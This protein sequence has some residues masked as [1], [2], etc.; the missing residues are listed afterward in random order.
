[1]RTSF[2]AAYI[3][4]SGIQRR[5]RRELIQR[6]LQLQ[7]RGL[8]APM[9]SAE[10]RHQE[11]Q[12]IPYVELLAAIF[13]KGADWRIATCLEAEHDPRVRNE[14]AWW[15]SKAAIEGDADEL[16]RFQQAVKTIKAIEETAPAKRPKALALLFVLRRWFE[17]QGLPTEAQV[18][19]FLIRAGIPL[20][21]EGRK[22]EAR[23]IFNGPILGTL[24]KG[25]PGRKPS[26][27]KYPSSKY[28]S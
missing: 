17:S 26:A 15:L 24:P 25:K 28:K 7:S 20:S 5:R 9:L 18:R 21:S 6:L 13:G 11:E 1:M 27:N 4:L 2:N 23:D 16:M 10:M 19:Q 8:S 14:L 12:E 3:P 22:N